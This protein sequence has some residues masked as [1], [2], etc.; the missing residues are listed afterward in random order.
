MDKRHIAAIIAHKKNIEKEK[1]KDPTIIQ[2]NSECTAASTQLLNDCN[3]GK[4]QVPE[5]MLNCIANKNGTSSGASDPVVDN[6]T[7]NPIVPDPIVPDPIAPIAPA[8]IAPIAPDPI[9]PIAPD[10]IVPIVPDPIVPIVP[11]TGDVNAN[12]STNTNATRND[13]DD[14][15]IDDAD[16]DIIDDADNYSEYS[17]NISEDEDEEI[18]CDS[19]FFE[20]VRALINNKNY[21]VKNRIL[22]KGIK[23]T[24]DSITDLQRV[25]KDII[26]S[27]NSISRQI[28]IDLKNAIAK[29]NEKEEKEKEKAAKE[30]KEVTQQTGGADQEKLEEKDKY[31]DKLEQFELDKKTANTTY[32]SKLEELENEKIQKLEE[33]LK[34]TDLKKLDAIFNSKKKRLDDELNRSLN[35]IKENI[36]KVTEEK[37]KNELKKEKDKKEKEISNEKELKANEVKNAEF[38][39]ARANL[40]TIKSKHIR[41]AHKKMLK[42]F[43]KIYTN[44]LRWNIGFVTKR[45]NAVRSYIKYIDARGLTGKVK[46]QN[47]ENDKIKIFYKAVEDLSKGVDEMLTKIADVMKTNLEP[48][49]QGDIQGYLTDSD[50]VIELKDNETDLHEYITKVQQKILSIYRYEYNIMDIIFDSQFIFLYILKILVFLSLL[51]SFYLGERIFSDLYMRKVY[52]EGLDPP[53]ILIYL[54]IFLAI[55][56]GF[57]LFVVTFLFLI[58]FLFGS[59]TGFIVDKYL[60]KKFTID[61]LFLLFLLSMFAIIIGLTIQNKKYFRYKTEGLRALRAYKTIL[62]YI[63]G[64]LCIIPL[65]ALF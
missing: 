43:K 15:I 25:E 38:V 51:L 5:T 65:F 24:N 53:H 10:P 41:N 31:D 42:H 7:T 23:I 8:P 20:F 58:M 28:L 36:I 56:F 47:D 45:V 29:D 64:V 54:G 26:D 32:R 30:N 13:A 17:Y 49:R 55:N 37:K 48:Y 62:A 63:A 27:V 46:T 35:D 22:D 3:G 59:P 44:Q 1:H 39:K 61:Y 21:N 52:G 11:S 19:S 14:D 2:N 6:E 12:G 18:D 50:V 57:F 9:A 4:C 40:T 16:D 34:Q 60:I 33:D